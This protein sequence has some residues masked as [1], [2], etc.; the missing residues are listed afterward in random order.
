MGGIEFGKCDI[1]GKENYL[2]RTYFYYLIDCVCCESKTNG[3]KCHFEKV[4][5]CH[6]CIPEIPLEIHPYIIDN[7]GHECKISI[8]GIEPINIEGKH[9]IKKQ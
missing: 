3:H 1:C 9:S 7:T 8:S 6:D 4:A 5:H 2:E